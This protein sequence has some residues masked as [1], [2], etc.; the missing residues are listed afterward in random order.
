MQSNGLGGVTDSVKRPILLAKE[1]RIRWEVQE[2]N[3]R[4]AAK[5]PEE[6]HEHTEKKETIGIKYSNYESDRE[7]YTNLHDSVEL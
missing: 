4:M 1:D 5:A 2:E 6:T 7:T 3:G